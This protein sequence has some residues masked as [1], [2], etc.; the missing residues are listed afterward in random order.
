MTDW[1][2]KFRTSHFQTSHL[3]RISLV[4]IMW[5]ATHTKPFR[6]KIEKCIKS[7][8]AG[9]VL[10]YYFISLIVPNIHHL[11]S[12]SS[13]LF[14]GQGQN[15]GGKQQGNHT[16]QY[17]NTVPLLRSTRKQP[18]HPS[19]WNNSC[20]MF[21]TSCRWCGYRYRGAWVIAVNF[22][23]VPFTMLVNCFMEVF[24]TLDE[25]LYKKSE[26]KY[27]CEVSLPWQRHLRRGNGDRDLHWRIG[28][29]LN[30]WATSVDKVRTAPSIMTHCETTLGRR[31]STI[32]IVSFEWKYRCLRI[33]PFDFV[34]LSLPVRQAWWWWQRQ[35]WLVSANRQSTR[36]MFCGG[37]L[38]AISIAQAE[39][40]LR[41]LQERQ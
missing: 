23:T 13:V 22:L 2:V 8:E 31:C 40:A 33:F 5:N 24:A 27:Y 36:K 30:I 16:T 29:K 21:L 4:S 17:N 28:L 20:H 1:L 34:V 7:V 9:Y 11:N 39:A 41:K 6:S 19:F 38:T 26:P 3:C 35:Q 12:A 32:R 14:P 15:S 37:I 25:I 18:I 10:F